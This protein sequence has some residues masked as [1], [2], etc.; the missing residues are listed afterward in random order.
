MFCF[1][2]LLVSSDKETTRTALSKYVLLTSSKFTWESI[3]VLGFPGK[4]HVDKWIL[5]KTHVVIVFSDIL[6]GTF[7][8]AAIDQILQV[9]Y[10]SQSLDFQDTSY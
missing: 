2:F 8:L 3:G 6:A 5:Y 7:T 10:L 1:Q 9:K 4:S